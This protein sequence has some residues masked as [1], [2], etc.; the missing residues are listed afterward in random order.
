MVINQ[1]SFGQSWEEAVKE[2]EGELDLYWHESVPFIDQVEGEMTGIEYE[3]IKLFQQY[4][5]DRHDVDLKLNWIATES[6]LEALEITK[7]ATQLNQFGISVFSITPERRQFVRFTDPYL[8][9]VTVLVSGEGSRIVQT[10]DEMNQML[11]NMEAVTIKGT[12]YEGF[13]KDLKQQLNVDFKITY[14]DSNDNVLENIKSSANRFAF[15]DLPIYLLWVKRGEKLVRQNFFTVRGIGYAFIMPTESDWDTPFNEFLRDSTYQSKREETIA[16]YLGSGLYE[17]LSELDGEISIG[18]SLLTKEKELQLELL[19]NTNLLLE[20][21]KSLQRVLLMGIGGAAVFALIIGFMF[22]KNQQKAK[23]LSDQHDQ[24][25]TQQE[26]IKQKNEQLINRNSQL[27]GLNEEKNSLVRILAHDLRSPIN[28]I[29]GFS[30]LLKNSKISD[31]DQTIVQYIAESGHK[32][33]T[34]ITK[35]MN[36]GVME[37]KSSLLLKEKVNVSSILHDISERYMPLAAKKNIK[38]DIDLCTEDCSLETDHLLLFL[39]IENLVSNAVKFSPLK[40]VVQVNVEKT[41]DQMTF[42][43]IDQGPGFTEEDQK[44]MYTQF[45]TL[46]ATPTGGENSTGIGLSIVKKYVA[47]LDGD[48]HLESAEGKGSTFRVTLPRN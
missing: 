13:L 34:M 12:N 40:S 32:L 48:I 37:G 44:K 5:K 7:D 29:I 42:I 39:V 24:I 3:I 30:D 41:D 28:Q 2:G 21:E 45:Q 35:I 23:I 16:G 46:S 9:D 26:D 20:E 47:L 17:F 1:F 31:Q 8:P 11:A 14:I 36:E 38:L 33:N 22:F 25:V 10:F 4:V 6:F 15:I 18:T 19:K 27:I 43:I